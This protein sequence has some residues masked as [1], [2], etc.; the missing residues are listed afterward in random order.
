VT[1]PKPSEI[2][3]TLVDAIA[4]RV[5]DRLAK[6]T[7]ATEYVY[8]DE[9]V[10]VL[11]TKERARKMIRSGQLEGSVVG[12]RLVVRRTSLEAFIEQH[13]A[14]QKPKPQASG[15]TVDVD[16]DAITAA[17]GLRLLGGGRR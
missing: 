5:A 2:L 12:R 9:L 3:D 11:G 6:R 13:R 8:E 15:N 14:K 17:G 16:L 4:E 1:A 7:P 10:A